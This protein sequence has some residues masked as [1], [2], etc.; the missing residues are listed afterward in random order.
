[1]K[2]ILLLIVTMGQIYGSPP[3]LPQELVDEL[4]TGKYDKPVPTFRYKRD[5]NFEPQLTEW[6]R[7][8]LHNRPLPAFPCPYPPVPYLPGANF[9]PQDVLEFRAQQNQPKRPLQN[10]NPLRILGK[11]LLRR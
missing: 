6:E 3:P 10:L 2:Y 11:G 5:W 9:I 4:A 7:E 1:M 8:E